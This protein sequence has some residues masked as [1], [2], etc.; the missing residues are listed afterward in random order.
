M[1]LRRIFIFV[2]FVMLG[3]TAF[4]QGRM[5]VCGPYSQFYSKDSLNIVTFGASTVQG[6]PDPLNFQTSLKSFLENCYTGKPVVIANHGIAG[7]NTTQGLL[8]FDKAIENKTGFVLILMGANDAVQIIDGNEKLSNTL[9]N[10]RTMIN[11]ARSRKL[12][13]ILGTIQYFV[14]T[15][16]RTPA[17]RLSQRRN[18]TIDMIN[19]GYKNLAKELGVRVADINS[20]IGKNKQLYADDV[21]PNAKGY[22]VISLMWF[23]ALNQEIIENYLSPGIVQ[24]YPNPANTFTKLGFNLPNAARVKITLYNIFGQRVA[25]VFDDYRNAGYQEENIST[26]MYAA[27]VYVLH[28]ELLG[29]KFSKKLVIVH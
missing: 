27:G 20:L 17:A 5:P 22:G 9:S 1:L 2:C 26:E 21:H 8:R 14:E 16:G 4:S 3:V 6:N 11:K 12:A 28:Y 13:V 23:D 29:H 24:N 7:E 19:N 10:M 15:P 18:R 25:V